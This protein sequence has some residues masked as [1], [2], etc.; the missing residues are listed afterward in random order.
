MSHRLFARLSRR[1]APAP[2]PV[3]RREFLR[4][5]LAAGAAALLS[6]HGAAAGR[7]IPDGRRVLVIGAGFAG[8][9]CAYELLAAGYDVHILEGRDRVGGRVLSLSNFVPGKN[10]EA[11][12]ELIG[13]NHPL[14]L[15]YAKRFKLKFLRVSEYED[16]HAPVL[17]DGRALTAAEQ[18]QLWEEWDAAVAPLNAR[19]AAIDADEPWNSPDAAALDARSV[20]DWLSAQQLSPLTR[21]AID[22]V[23]T[24]DNG[25]AIARQ[26]YLGLLTAIRGGGGEKFWTES[27][28]LRC[29]GGNQQLA[30]RLAE[31]IG[32]ARILLQHKVAAVRVHADSVAVRDSDGR[33]YVGDH[34]V[35]AVPPPIW[36]SIAID[37]PLPATLLPQMGCNV[38][39]LSALSRAVWTDGDLAPDAVTDGHVAM[40]WDPTDAQAGAG[41][42]LVAFSGGPGAEAI[43]AL[44]AESRKRYYTATLDG[45]YAG[46]AGAVQ[47]TRFMDWPSDPWV[48]GSYS[49]PAPGQIMTQG[50]AL[51]DGI[52]RLHFAGEHTCYRFAGYMEGALQSGVAAARRIAARDG[53]ADVR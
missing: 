21:R 35:L 3:S 5:T 31:A 29:A 48:G 45:L 44:D 14:W 42:G 23:L 41:A 15:A 28:V 51:R 40:T 43:R 1:F 25:V 24:A 7:P 6:G 34:V 12:G 17:L 26:S 19:S 50:P 36:R 22:V 9:A 27:E 33:A 18:Q 32:P 13:R 2:D 37:P 47:A 49:F 38:K 8:L 52:G 30:L 4:A 10:V 46:Y 53:V 39:H 16:L 11:G 20:G